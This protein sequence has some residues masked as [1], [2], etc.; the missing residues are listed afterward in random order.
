VIASLGLLGCMGAGDAGYQAQSSTT[1]GNSDETSV[2]SPSLGPASPSAYRLPWQCGHVYPVTQGNHGD[3]CGRLGNHLGVEE[4]AWD[5]GLPM[6]TPVVAARAGKITLAETPSPPGSECYNG[7]PGPGGADLE[8]QACCSK[9]L[10]SANKV[11]VQH[12]DGVI[13]SYSHLDEVVV[14]VGDTVTAGDLLGYSGTTGCSTGPHLH[15]QIMYGCPQ[16]YCQSL[17]MR[18]EDAD[19]PA[20]GNK[21]I[22]QNACL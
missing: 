15:F 1:G 14:K 12:A 17:P 22:S 21:A 16:G 18:F 3:I 2:P 19:V 5:F 11:N 10:Y 9:C 13:S 7:C 6:R 20:C 4:F 8:Q